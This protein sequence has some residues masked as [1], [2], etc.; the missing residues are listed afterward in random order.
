MPGAFP[1]SR[2]ANPVRA[3]LGSR[4]IS[5]LLPPP[6]DSVARSHKTLVVFRSIRSLGDGVPISGRT[7]GTAVRLPLFGIDKQV[8][9]G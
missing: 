6:F 3:R 8:T 4:P 1:P 5:S 9:V 2:S 7:V